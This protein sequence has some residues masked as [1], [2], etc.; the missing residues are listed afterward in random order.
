LLTQGFEI[1]STMLVNADVASRLATA[2]Q[3]DTIMIILQKGADSA[4][5]WFTLSAW[6]AQNIGGS[7]CNLLQ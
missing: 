3:P 1:K 2:T 7:A 5:C 6:N 4:N